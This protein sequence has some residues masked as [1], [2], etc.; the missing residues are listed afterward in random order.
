MMVSSLNYNKNPITFI[1]DSGF[2]LEGVTEEYMIFLTLMIQ[3]P[4]MM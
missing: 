1:S 2:S 3:N 4:Q